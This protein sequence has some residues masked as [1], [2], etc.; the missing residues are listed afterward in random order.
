MITTN[1]EAVISDET[2]T[3]RYNNYLRSIFTWGVFRNK[4]AQNRKELNLDEMRRT[5]EVFGNP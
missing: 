1:P 4:S 3:A 2:I 5:C